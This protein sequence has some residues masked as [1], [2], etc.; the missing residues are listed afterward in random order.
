M[1]IATFGIDLVKYSCSVVGSDDSGR[2]VVRR[3]MHRVSVIKFC[4][5]SDAVRGCDRSVLWRSP[6]RSAPTGTR[7]RDSVNVALVCPP[8]RQGS[9]E[10]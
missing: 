7:P 3:R 8:L 10:R 6:S 4:R 9:E 1:Q 2:V 5:R